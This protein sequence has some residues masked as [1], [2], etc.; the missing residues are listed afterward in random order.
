MLYGLKCWAFTEV[1]TCRCCSV[2]DDYK[3]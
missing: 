3:R 1:G 2:S